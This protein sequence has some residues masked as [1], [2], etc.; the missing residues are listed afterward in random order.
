MK[1]AIQTHQEE[2]LPA[3]AAAARQAPGQSLMVRA[4]VLAA[5][6]ALSASVVSAGLALA[7]S[8]S[9]PVEMFYNVNW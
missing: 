2:H 7:D 4:L 6:F 5:S 8:P 3:P 1:V 9:E